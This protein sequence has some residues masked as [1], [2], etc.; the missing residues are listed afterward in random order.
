MTPDSVAALV[1]LAREGDRSAFTRLVHRFQDFAVA[2]AYARLGDPEAARDAAQEALVDG[3]L[4]LA[5]LR[6]PAAFPGWLRR[7]VFKHCDRLVRGTRPAIASLDRVA[8]LGDDAPSA[9]EALAIGEE[10][11]RLRAALEALPEQ[12]RTLLALQ[13]LGGQ[14]QR[15]IAFLLELPLTTVKKRLHTA[16]RRLRERWMTMVQEELE[17]LRPAESFHGRPGSFVTPERAV[18]DVEALLA[19][20]SEELDARHYLYRGTLDDVR[21][22]AE[23]EGGDPASPYGARVPG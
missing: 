19:E 11:A 3:Y 20:S 5:Q 6:E 15:E 22:A 18:E 8:E 1:T 16:R 9:S 4:H 13:Y 14:G 23:R 12:E 2:C 17:T 21:A 7:I 10:Q